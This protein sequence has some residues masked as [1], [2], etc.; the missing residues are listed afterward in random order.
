MNEEIG[1]DSS[2]VV[3]IAEQSLD[4]DQSWSSLKGSVPIIDNS[5]RDEMQISRQAAMPR[6]EVGS[7]LGVSAA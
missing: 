1:V 4:G 7:V 2:N 6:R 5:H 3:A